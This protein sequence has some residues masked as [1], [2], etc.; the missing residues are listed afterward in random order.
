M[1]GGMVVGGFDLP[2]ETINSR[3]L[4]R[5]TAFPS[6]KREYGVLPAPLSWIS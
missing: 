5:R 2:S 4:E 3:M 6:A 1:N